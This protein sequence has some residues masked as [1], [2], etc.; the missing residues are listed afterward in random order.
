V[1]QIKRSQ[2]GRQQPHFQ[3]TIK[4][5]IQCKSCR[6]QAVANAEALAENLRNIIVICEVAAVASLNR[7]AM[8]NTI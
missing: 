2:G 3:L 6:T 8:A 7:M 1:R 4:P 5:T